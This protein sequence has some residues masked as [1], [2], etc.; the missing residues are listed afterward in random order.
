MEFGTSW[1]LVVP[2]LFL[3]CHI[4]ITITP[5]CSN[6]A[7]TKLWHNHM[8]SGSLF[9][10]V[11]SIFSSF[12]HVMCHSSQATLTCRLIAS[13]RVVIAPFLPSC[14]DAHQTVQDVGQPNVFPS[15]H[16]LPFTSN[17]DMP[18]GCFSRSVHCPP[19]PHSFL[20]SVVFNSLNSLKC[21]LIFSVGQLS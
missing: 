15:I 5:R 11:S 21:F 14:V 20:V 2:A 8:S 1:W 17:L 6:S 7:T 12:P 19:F 13:V 16:T 10:I 9:L 3:C 18:S 4:P